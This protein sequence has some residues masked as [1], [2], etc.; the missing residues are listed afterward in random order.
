MTTHAE[1]PHPVGPPAAAIGS[2]VLMSAAMS[3][4]RSDLGD[5]IFLAA[6]L[7]ALVLSGSYTIRAYRQLSALEFQSRYIG[8]WIG[9]AFALIVNGF[10]AFIMFVPVLFLVGMMLGGKGI[11]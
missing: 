3:G 1:L 7:A 10:E 2:A 11:S 5:G 8:R 6:A 9:V 4:G